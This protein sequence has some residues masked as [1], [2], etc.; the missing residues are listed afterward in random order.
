M[1]KRTVFLYE[2][3]FLRLKFSFHI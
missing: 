1:L 3:D 2:L